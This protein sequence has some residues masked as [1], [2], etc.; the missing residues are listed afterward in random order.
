MLPP[1]G[2]DVDCLG[3]RVRSTGFAPLWDWLRVAVAQPNTRTQT[4]A[5]VNAHS[6]NLAYENAAYRAVLN[7]FH[8]VLNDGAGLELYSMACGR[9]F[10]T[11]FVGTDL[12]PNAFLAARE[13][14][15]PMSVYLFGGRPG[16]AKSAAETFAGR[17][18]HVNFVGA[19]DGYGDSPSRVLSDLERTRPDVLLVAMGNPLQETW[20]HENRHRLFAKV[21]CGVGAFFD[22]ACGAVPR[23]P[24]WMRR[25]RLEWVYRLGFEPKRM[26]DRYV[27]GNP[28]FAVRSARYLATGRL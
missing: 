18:A 27:L 6:L 12:W 16:R 15:R 11:N 25:A 3:V 2:E 14:D 9:H 10:S 21:A 24:A 26:F 7:A 28:R 8:L 1:A 17:Y 23:A 13:L 19:M 22:F 5:I 4:M 20:I